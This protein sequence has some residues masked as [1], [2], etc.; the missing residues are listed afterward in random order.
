MAKYSLA[1]YAG[2]PPDNGKARQCEAALAKD[3]ISGRKAGE[4][5]PKAPIHGSNVCSTHGGRA[6]QVKEAA[7][8][9]LARL[10]DPAIELAAMVMEI[11]ARRARR[12]LRASNKT[13]AVPDLKLGINVA[14]DVL[15]R[16]GYKGKQ[17]LTVTS[18]NIDPKNLS[19]D[20]L[21]QIIALKEQLGQGDKAA[22]PNATA[23]S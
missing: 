21:R 13:G 15:D 12:A 14:Q 22:E 20:M 11:D 7:A 17:E 3:G 19:E 5:C 8:M 6:P 9:R 23:T 2:Q 4:R 1:T 10:V 18:Y 16:T